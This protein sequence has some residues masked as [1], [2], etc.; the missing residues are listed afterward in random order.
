MSSAV[1]LHI[2]P[3][4]A[5]LLP[6]IIP[7][8]ARDAAANISF[9]NVQTF[10]E[11]NYGFVDLPKEMA[12]KLKKKLN[13]TTLKGS[14]L[15]VEE[16][17]PEVRSAKS[18]V[19]GTGED[20]EQKGLARRRSER[21]R[22]REEGVVPGVELP[23]DRKVKRGWTE[24]AAQIRTRKA[25]PSADPEPKASKSKT[26]ASK[27]TNKQECLFKTQAPDNST[28]TDTSAKKK[29]KRKSGETTVHE[30]ENT[31]KHASFLKDSS[32]GDDEPRVEAFDDDK[33][34][35]GADGSVIEKPRKSKRRSNSKA[36]NPKAIAADAEGA[37]QNV[38]SLRI[39]PSE[40]AKASRSNA[41]APPS[42][43][44]TTQTTEPTTAA[45]ASPHPLES[46]F[47][48]P[49]PP[50]NNGPPT[51]KG[52][53]PDLAVNV[54]FHFF[55][56]DDADGDHGEGEGSSQ[57]SAGASATKSRSGRVPNLSIPMTPFTQRD[58][59]WRRQRSAA[60]TPDTAA[61]GK[62]GLGPLWGLRGDDDVVGE[63]EDV[64]PGI[65]EESIDEAEDKT[66]S[67]EETTS[68]A[69]SVHD[70]D[71]E[72][73]DMTEDAPPAAAKARSD[74]PDGAKPESDFAKWF[75]ENR[76]NNNRAW[77]KRRRE[78]AKE[79]RKRENKRRT[80]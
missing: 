66:S 70:G 13:G 45:S 29:G 26:Q 32:G 23:E 12:D 68:D 30:F 9:H 73:E 11:R 24:S 59:T 54:P 56:G 38:G 19:E 67:D 4:T 20:E 62:V 44:P 33:G 2:S 47:K 16:A 42:P 65:P 28:K 35:V 6:A 22:K 71:K 8:S 10:P 63:E 43:P 15:K 3:F 34:W 78:A 74:Q 50:N 64:V 75:W 53:K 25:K 27:F 1:R 60:P 18:G 55:D 58:M 77:K 49:A 39:S 76:G 40:V 61:P 79:Q 5:E 14:K 48:K 36:S 17:K 31:T 57:P 80:A 41:M 69:S 51:G 7:P 37:A 52:R 21:K 46:L 72:D